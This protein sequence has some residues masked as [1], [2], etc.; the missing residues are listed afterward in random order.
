MPIQ[1]STMAV[2]HN[3]LWVGTENGAMLAFPFSTPAA[4]AEESG[5]ELI[6]VSTYSGVYVTCT[7]PVHVVCRHCKVGLIHGAMFSIQEA[8]VGV[9]IPE[10]FDVR[11]EHAV[12]AGDSVTE[13]TPMHSLGSSRDSQTAGIVAHKAI[14]SPTS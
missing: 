10:P 8:E 2:A 3:T 5:W 4:I 7:H 1:V 13:S 12:E 14:L 11:T 9:S 6:K